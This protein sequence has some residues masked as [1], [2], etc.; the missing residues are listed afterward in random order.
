MAILLNSNFE[1]EIL[2]CNKD[3]NGNYLNLLM[4]LS[5]M[6]IN[7][8]TLYGPNNDSPSSFEEISKLLENANG[9][10]N[11]LCGDFNVA[12]DNDIDTFNYRHVN[13]PRSRQAIFD[14][15]RQYDLSDIYRDLHPDTKR[16][17]WRRRNLVKQARLD[18]FLASSNIL[19]I[20]NTCEIRASY[21]S[22]HSTIEL[23]MK[24][25]KFLQGK[26]LWKFNNS[27]LECP[28]YVDLINGIIEEEKVKYAIP[29]Y[30]LDFLKDNFTSFEM[31]ID[32]DLFL[33]TL[34]LRIRGETIKFATT[35]KKKSS[36]VEKQ[37]ISDIEFLEAQDPNYTANS[38][39]LL[40]KRAE[41]ESIRSK[42][43]KGQLVRS[44][45]QWLQDGE[46]PSKY[47]SNLE[48]KNFIEKTIRKVRLNNGEVIT[49][50]ENILSQVQQYYSNLFENRDDALQRINFE[51]LGIKSSTRVPEE[52]IG[53]LVTVDEVGQVL[54]KMKSSKSPGIDGITVE[55]VKVF[56]RQVKYFIINAINCG[57]SK[58]CLTAS[59]RQC[60]IT[61]LPK[62]KKDRSLIKNWR[63]ISLLSVIYK[64]A[65]G[66]IAERL[67]K[68]LNYVISDCQTGFI[69]GRYISESTRLI[70]DLI[71]A[72]ENKNIPGML[73]L[74]DFEKAFDSLSWSFLYR[75]LEFF[76]YSENFIKWVKLFN[77]EITA[78][79]VQCGFLSKPIKINRGCRQGD[80][81]S[82]YLFLIGAEILARLIQINPY[83]I[84][85][86]I[87]NIEF[88][89]TQ[90]ADDTTPN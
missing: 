72:K 68:T 14:L 69:K 89:I 59:L 5:S 40:D 56:W 74:I 23:E 83:I 1:Y 80:P 12:L 88:K 21:R 37:L 36:K 49:D 84:G 67:K 50:Q 43:L 10:Y 11:I 85:L 55:F 4:K 45:L 7:L 24:I 71:H 3:K 52:D 73:M 51:N 77:T 76:G 31:I 33:E 63:P 41:L 25:N 61:C 29:V 75:V 58:G 60:I 26:G 8:I 17:T 47:F 32:H 13:N 46:K 79:I 19:D 62:A 48:K 2:A 16:F 90:F 27:L 28:E 78:Y 30:N 87:K 39:L 15:M 81:I 38:T 64:L 18:L 42:K 6:K 57:F 53:L 35:Q 86:K 65:S 20:T 70:Y 66:T 54:K 44:R 22:D 82:A 34:L 9:D